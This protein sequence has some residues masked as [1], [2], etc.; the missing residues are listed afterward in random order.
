MGAGIAV[1]FRDKFRQIEKLKAQ[2]VKA[3]GVAILQD[4][5]R[6]IY[7]LISKN[8][9]YKKP[10]YQ[11][12]FLSLNAMKNHMVRKSLHCTAHINVCS[13]FFMFKKN[14]FRYKIM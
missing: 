3:G 12:L 1:A 5:S 4:E 14:I 10:T 2:N 8:D 6:F 7:Y 9:T 11:D 13:N